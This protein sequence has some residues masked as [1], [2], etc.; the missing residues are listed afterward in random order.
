MKKIILLPLVSSITLLTS[1]ASIVS[2][3]YQKIAV[4]THP[5]QGA[6]CTLQNNKGSWFI[7]QT[8]AIIQVHR[9]F[10]NLTVDCERKG[11][12]K[13]QSIIRSSTKALA[14]GNVI[15]GGAVGAGVD[16]ANGSAYDYPKAIV[17]PLRVLKENL[18]TGRKH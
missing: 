3:R 17:V 15:L 6:Q 2:G 13:G 7:Q 9:S 10:E 4:N 8:P 12:G 18:R 14:F 5:V 1:C 11:Y 16:I